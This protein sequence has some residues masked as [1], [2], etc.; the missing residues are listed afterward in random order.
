MNIAIRGGHNWNIQ[1]ADGIVNEVGK[2]REIYPKIIEWLQKDGNVV[3][4]VTP[5]ATDSKSE[6][7]QYGVSRANDWCADYFC[8]IHLNASNGNGHGT[9]ALYESEEGRI[10]AERIAN[11]VASLGFTNRGAKPNERGLY[12]LNNTNMVSNIIETFFC[13]NQGDVDLYNSVGVDLFA[14]KVAEGIVGHEINDLECEVDNMRLPDN[15]NDEKYLNANPDVKTA[16][17]NGAF[18]DGADHWLQYGYREP[19]RYLAMIIPNVV[20]TIAKGV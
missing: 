3:L 17:N 19:H 11:S 10:I 20:E 2:D 16:V 18:K 13:D 9:E 12:E 4:D 15:W 14:K 1:G 8:S 7:L 6:D 5:N